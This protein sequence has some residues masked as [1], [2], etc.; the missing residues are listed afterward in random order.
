MHLMGI[1]ETKMLNFNEQYD[2]WAKVMADCVDRL[3]W[4]RYDTHKCET[5]PFNSGSLTTVLHHMDRGHINKRKKRIV[6]AYHHKQK[7]STDRPSRFQHHMLRVHD[8]QVRPS[9]TFSM[10][11]LKCSY[12][13]Q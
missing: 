7:F 6:C 3:S 11:V 1:K 12:I 13:V 10:W 4:R 8:L 9:S 2:L 5:C